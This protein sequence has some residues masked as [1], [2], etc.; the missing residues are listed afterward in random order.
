VKSTLV[1]LF[2]ATA[3]A[4]ATIPAVA[5][6]APA[7]KPTKQAPAYGGTKDTQHGPGKTTPYGADGKHKGAY[8][9][10]EASAKGEAAKADGMAKA[11][12]A[13]GEAA[14]KG[15]AA[16]AEGMAKADAAKAGANPKGDEMQARRDERKAI[17]ETYRQES[18][19]G[20]AQAG[21]KPW[22]KFWQG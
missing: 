22:W 10:A 2:L 17:Q 1:P 5:N 19:G 12:A 4:L 6:N 8:T 13:K 21:K 7:N 18:E 14:T 11:Q 3:V 16:K 9:K 20:S 15:D